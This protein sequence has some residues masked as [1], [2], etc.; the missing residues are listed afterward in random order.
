MHY[1]NLSAVRR[2]LKE[3]VAIAT[4]LL[5]RPTIS[6]LIRTVFG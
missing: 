1:E 3:H 6:L 2:Y 4:E 5:R